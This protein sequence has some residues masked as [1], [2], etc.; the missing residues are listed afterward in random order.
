MEN[1][2]FSLKAKLYFGFLA[3]IFLAVILGVLAVLAFRTITNEVASTNVLV[4]QT[5]TQLNPLTTQYSLLAASAA[6]AGGNFYA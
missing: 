1:A 2:V 4:E 3:M 6:E 5:A